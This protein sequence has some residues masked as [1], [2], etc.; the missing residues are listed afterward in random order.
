MSLSQFFV[1]YCPVCRRSFRALNGQPWTCP[2]SAKHQPIK[3][4]GPFEP[5]MDVKE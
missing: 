3:I 4:R 2:V 1:G 5:G